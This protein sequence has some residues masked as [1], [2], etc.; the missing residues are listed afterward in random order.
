MIAGLRLRLQYEFFFSFHREP[1]FPMI[2]KIH[3][4][5]KYTIK[6]LNQTQCFKFKNI[7]TQPVKN[8]S[9]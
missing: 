5:N 8:V 3:P 7:Y 1:V 4:I 9:T 6:G 2:Y